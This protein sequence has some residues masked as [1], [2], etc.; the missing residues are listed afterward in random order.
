MKLEDNLN[1]VLSSPG[2]TRKRIAFIGIGVLVATVVC[3]SVIVAVSVKSSSPKSSSI[4]MRYYKRLG[5]TADAI[6]WVRYSSQNFSLTDAFAGGTGANGDTVYVCRAEHPSKTS[7]KDELIP[8][9]FFPSNGSCEVPYDD[10]A[11][12]HSVFDLLI[13]KNPSRLLWANESKGKLQSGTISGGY[14]AYDEELYISRF[15]TYGYTVLGKIHLAHMKASGPVE[16]YERYSEDY[17]VLCF[18]DYEL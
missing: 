5:S 6:K 3:I 14:T 17:D 7:Y 2:L 10:K 15:R 4:S 11:N 1:E 16:G 18:V 12:P 13:T 8:G 9:T